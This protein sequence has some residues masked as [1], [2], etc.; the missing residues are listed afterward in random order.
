[1]QSLAALSQ[2]EALHQR[3]SSLEQQQLQSVLDITVPSKLGTRTILCEFTIDKLAAASWL[4]KSVGTKSRNIKLWLSA[5]NSDPTTVPKS[6]K[7]LK[8]LS[9]SDFS[10][11]KECPLSIT[12]A[13]L[14]TET[15][16]KGI[17]K[18]KKRQVIAKFRKVNNNTSK[19]TEIEGQHAVDTYINP[20]IK[21]LF[22]HL[23]FITS[24]ADTLYNTWECIGIEKLDDMWDRMKGY[25]ASD[26]QNAYLALK[27]LHSKGFIHGDSHMANFMRVPLGSTEHPVD[28]PGRIIMIDQDSIRRLP[29]DKKFRAA[30]KYLM[31]QDL[32]TLL[33]WNNQFVTVIQDIDN[34]DEKREAM[35][36]VYQFG[37]GLI[38]PAT[39][40]FFA[41]TREKSFQEIDTMLK[42]PFAQDYLH[43]L[44]LKS[45]GEIYRYYDKC[46]SSEAELRNVHKFLAE[47]Y[48]RVKHNK[49]QPV[50]DITP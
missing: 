13:E 8:E 4:A 42:L 43:L 46:F 33:L 25:S 7:V 14:E 17:A 3:L 44:N 50:W 2:L 28:N 30:S 39:P 15:Y 24:V 31:I 29:V 32:N 5:N 47:E 49:L 21:D 20:E 19:M 12:V 16:E 22:P 27:A 11:G 45:M 37:K 36:K 6:L 26:Y 1:M 35:A 48:Q 40:Y 9:Y 18:S 23:Y 38:W 34:D 10:Y 41:N